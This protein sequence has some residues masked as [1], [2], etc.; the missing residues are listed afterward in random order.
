[1]RLIGFFLLILVI[2]FAAGDITVT[3]EYEGNLKTG[4]D[5]TF[6]I[7]VDNGFSEDADITLMDKNV[8][9]NNGIN[10]ECLEQTVPANSQVVMN[11]D[12]ITL[13]E[14]GTFQIQ[15]A[16]IEYDGNT[17]ES[18]SHELEVTGKSQ[19]GNQAVTNI[20]RCNGVS[21]TSQSFSSS[22][23]SQFTM[24]M[25]NQQSG[26]QNQQQ[27]SQ[28]QQP[29][30][31][32][33]EIQNKVDQTQQN[34]HQDSQATKQALEEERKRQDE[35]SRQLE[36][37]LSQNQ[38]YQEQKEMLENMGFNQSSMPKSS[39]TK[40]EF[41]TEFQNKQGE[42]ATISGQVDNNDTNGNY[43]NRTKVSDIKSEFQSSELLE[44][45]MN[46]DNLFNQQLLKETLDNYNNSIP[47]DKFTFESQENETILKNELL[48]Q[49]VRLDPET[50]EL[51]DKPRFFNNNWLW[52]LVLM[53]LIISGLVLYK[54][55]PEKKKTM[56]K[57]DKIEKKID[58]KKMALGFL[59][60][61]KELFDNKEYK[62]AYSKASYAI[63]FFY[64]HELNLKKE[65]T[66]YDTLK[67]LKAEKI[68]FKDAKEALGL[69][70]L[71]E[72]AKYKPNRK[73]FNKIIDI[74]TKIIVKD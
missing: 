61:A 57:Q 37:Q 13:F 21:R 8:I 15:P 56:V 35:M 11:Y 44:K 45:I 68:G 43:S 62:E 52:W 73:D 24:N 38:E 29:P 50:G 53:L 32:R 31:T 48:K 65:L 74:S 17:Y 40:E 4:E 34:M 18:N 22:S 54:Y 60:E 30:T 36:E 66:S 20:F 25:G 71:V 33:D 9:S 47:P 58:H 10:V 5:I 72:F 55:W 16:K 69:C 26:Q 6:K 49:P 51:L 67:K 46:N 1:M 28:G 3:K 63:R 42:T 64:S 2:P 59:D 27:A 23:G 41:K 70:S 19:G 12:P 39:A 14:P 7:I